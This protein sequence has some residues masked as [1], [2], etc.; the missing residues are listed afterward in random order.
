[1]AV[2]GHTVKHAAWTVEN[3][4]HVALQTGLTIHISKTKYIINGQKMGNEQKETEINGQK[5][6]NVL[7]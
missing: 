3:K 4:T 2:L 7:L 5:Y 6:E 1:M